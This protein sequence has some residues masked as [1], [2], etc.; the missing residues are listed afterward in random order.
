MKKSNGWKSIIPY[1][2]IP[3]IL[4]TLFA[5]KYGSINSTV[6]LLHA[7][8]LTIVYFAVLT[9]IREKKVANQLVVTEL[10][11][12]FVILIPYLFVDTEKAFMLMIS[13]GVGFILAA[14]VFLTVYFVSRGGLG[15]GD[16]KLMIV[17]GL[18][19]GFNGVMPT[20]FY[21]SLLAALTAVVLILI[22]KMKRKDSFPLV[23]FLYIGMLITVFVQ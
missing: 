20:M 1:T 12:W 8:L 13:G 7:T 2:G 18:Y 4:V 17:S 5:T 22:K 21:G 14:A 10:L 23:P 16:V 11:F 3:L 19:L 15:G 9:D 6:L